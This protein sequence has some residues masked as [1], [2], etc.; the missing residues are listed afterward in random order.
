VSDAG[1]GTGTDDPH[2]H[3]P[4]YDFSDEILPAGASWWAML[5]EGQL[6]IRNNAWNYGK[7]VIS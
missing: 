4:L 5:L 1:R 3:H 6:G 2:L 7:I